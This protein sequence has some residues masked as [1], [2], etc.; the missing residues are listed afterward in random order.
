VRTNEIRGDTP[1]CPPLVVAVVG[2]NVKRLGE[3]RPMSTFAIREKATGEKFKSGSVHPPQISATVTVTF[4]L[5][6][7]RLGELL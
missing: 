1:V 2:L 4:A 7:L 3:I 5:L 6:S